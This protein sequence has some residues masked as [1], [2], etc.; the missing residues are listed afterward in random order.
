M[1][2]ERWRLRGTTLEFRKEA[3]GDWRDWRDWS[4]K[5]VAMRAEQRIATWTRETTGMDSMQW[6]TNLPL[7][8]EEQ[9]A[10]ATAIMLDQ[11]PIELVW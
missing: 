9:V 2:E 4:F 3:T 8:E 11:H 6:V 7:T 5:I 1:Y 10:L